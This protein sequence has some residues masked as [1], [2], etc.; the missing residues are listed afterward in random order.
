MVG[1]YNFGRRFDLSESGDIDYGCSRKDEIRQSGDI[2][3]GAAGV[4][5]K[6]VYTV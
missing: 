4:P 6:G 1:H 5:G 2:P 3:S